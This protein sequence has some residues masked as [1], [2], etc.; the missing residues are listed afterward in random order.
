MP[1]QVAK[2]VTSGRQLD[3]EDG[4]VLIF[5]ANKSDEYHLKA[6][7]KAISAGSGSAYVEIKRILD[8]GPSSMVI[9]GER[10]AATYSELRIEMI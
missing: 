1:T 4:E 9:I 8:Q 10:F 2:R 5:E 7:V 6:E 3:L